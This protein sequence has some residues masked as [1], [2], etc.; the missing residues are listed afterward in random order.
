M[1]DNSDIFDFSIS[2]TNLGIINSLPPCGRP[3]TN[4]DE[5]DL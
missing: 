5:R 3:Y 1:A 4:P 2:E